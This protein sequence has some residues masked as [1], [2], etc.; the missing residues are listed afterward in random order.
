MT[1]QNLGSLLH[2]ARR[3]AGLS[4]AELASRAGVSNPTVRLAERSQGTIGTYLKLVAASDH[5][6]RIARVADP[7]LMGNH[8]A[9]VRRRKRM[10]QRV[11]S[12][13]SGLSLPT[14]VNLEK[15]FS[16]RLALLEAYLALLE[17]K[18]SLTPNR[19]EEPESRRRRLAPKTNQHSQDVVM[20]PPRLAEA[21]VRHFQPTGVVLDPCRGDGAF[22]NAF[23][24]HVQAE[25]SEVREH[26]DFMEWKRPV[27]WIISN[28]PWSRLRQ[29]LVKAMQTADDIVFLSALTHYSTKARVSAMR[30]HG[31]AMRS[32]VLCPEPRGDWP[33]SGFQLGAAHLQRGWAGPCEFVDRIDAWRHTVEIEDQNRTA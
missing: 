18:P 24:D 14:V 28:P 32:F 29:F 22:Y 10:T 19:R 33:R 17:R 3:H 5:T 6:V 27:D 9:D 25:W 1:D 20:T 21:I 31:F 7:G 26:R 13:T 30:D 23:P 11:A 8:L 2:D 16:G 4:Q 12:K 15:R